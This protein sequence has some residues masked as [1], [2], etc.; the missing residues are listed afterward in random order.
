MV[1][2]LQGASKA[3]SPYRLQMMQSHTRCPLDTSHTPSRRHLKRIR[4]TT[5]QQIVAILWM[6][7]M[8]KLC[9]SIIIVPKPNFTVQLCLHPARLNQVLIRPICRSPTL[10]DILPKLTNVLNII[11]RDVMSDDHN[12]KLDKK[13]SYLTTLV[14]QFGRNRLTRLPFGVVSAV[15]MFQWKINEIFKDM[16]NVFDIPNDIL[17][18]GYDA[19]RRGHDRT[20]KEV[21]LI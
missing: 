2:Y 1:M 10:T 17:I 7:K 3:L 8:I 15:D 4:Q 21:K 11:I 14:F 5:K 12:P 6:D 18:V 20:L 9:N 16:T 19:D 13:S